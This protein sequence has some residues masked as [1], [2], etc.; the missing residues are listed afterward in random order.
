MKFNFFIP[1]IQYD[2][3]VRYASFFAL[4]HDSLFNSWTKNY[5]AKAF[6][7]LYYCKTKYLRNFYTNIWKILKYLIVV[8]Y[9]I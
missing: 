3:I 4:I 8:I 5:V 7:L 6:M 9:I 1:V 2:S